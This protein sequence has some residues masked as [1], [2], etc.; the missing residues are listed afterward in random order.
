MIEM[1][2][3]LQNTLSI[4]K[5]QLRTHMQAENE[6]KNEQNTFLKRMEMLEVS[7]GYLN[8]IRS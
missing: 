3:E 7:F 5:Q 1:Q 4:A 2:I 6:L 8:H